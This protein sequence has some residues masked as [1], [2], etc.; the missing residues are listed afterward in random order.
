MLVY[1]VQMGDT[2]YYKI[3][4]TSNITNRLRTIQSGNP[5]RLSLIN[6][7]RCIDADEARKIEKEVHELLKDYKEYGEWFF[8][9]T[10]PE[11]FTALRD[12]YC[13]C[14]VH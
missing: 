1:L 14:S 2:Q 7:I 5:M 6:S 12:S 4:F 11:R 13:L 9:S 8:S 10:I 3:G